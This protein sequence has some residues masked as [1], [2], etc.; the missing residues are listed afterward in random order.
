MGDTIKKALLVVFLFFLISFVTAQEQV[1]T[2]FGFNSSEF[3]FTD[4]SGIDWIPKQNGTIQLQKN[5]KTLG[6]L[7]IALTGTVGAQNYKKY[8]TDQNWIWNYD[9]NLQRAFPLQKFIGVNE[10]TEQIEVTQSVEYFFGEQLPKYEVK[11]KNNLPVSITNTKF[12]LVL[13]QKRGDD[14]T[15]G[16]ETKRIRQNTLSQ[17]DLSGRIP[18][19]LKV[20]KDYL[21]DWSDTLQDFE[22]TNIIVGETSQFGPAVKLAAIGLTKNN[23]V[24][25]S[26]ASVTIDPQIMIIGFNPPGGTGVPDNDWTDG[27]NVRAKDG[28][29]ASSTAAD[30]SL[31]LTDFGFNGIVNDSA[32]RGIQMNL[33]ADVP[34]CISGKAFLQFELSGDGGTT[35]TDTN[36]LFDMSCGTGVEDFPMTGQRDT[37]GKWW[38]AGEMDDGNFII[39]LRTERFT[40]DASQINVDFVEARVFHIAPPDNNVIA[41]FAAGDYFNL[42][43][44]ETGDV[45]EANIVAYFPFDIELQDEDINQ[46][47]DY[48]RQQFHGTFSSNDSSRS[49]FVEDGYIGGARNFVSSSEQNVILPFHSNKNVKQGLTLN[50]WIKTD[51]TR[52]TI[53]NKGIS[54][55]NVDV[56]LNTNFLGRLQIRAQNLV[57][58]TIGDLTNPC[59]SA[60]DTD[61][62]AWHMVT[63]TYDGNE[64]RIYG[65]G[66]HSLSCGF[67]GNL[68]TGAGSR[69]GCTANLTNLA[70]CS[71]GLIDD[72]LFLDTPLTETQI[73]DLFENNI[74]RFR[75]HGSLDFNG[76]VTTANKNRLDVNANMGIPSDSNVGLASGDLN[77]LT[78]PDT[79][80]FGPLFAFNDK[81]ASGLGI[82]SFADYSLRWDLTADSNLFT[83]P[84]VDMNFTR[85]EYYGCNW[86]GYGDFNVSCNLCQGVAIE[87]DLAGGNM[88]IN[89][90]NGPGDY[91]L[92][93]LPINYGFISSE[94]ACV[95]RIFVT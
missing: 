32:I 21:F 77:T 65:D 6:Y 81:N 52:G 43:V 49:V 19:K 83:S 66:Q 70:N 54:L 18:K 37:W 92:N 26:G 23:G 22:V 56:R 8:S 59:T 25:P 27:N 29:V 82:E 24:F 64:F 91:D 76:L 79:Y 38:E 15:V 87:N 85:N 13:V 73:S 17:F 28:S 12:W 48:S 1:N 55:T 84:V 78:D 39:R 3:S 30:E 63:T 60:F 10:N 46:A 75:P 93:T 41:D 4:V 11:L 71:N 31:S 53:F 16:N 69:I 88:T 95:T 42:A 68:K 61:D 67:T 9:Q 74:S 20:N 5:N 7:A 2:N 72:F 62:N 94:I 47:I 50:A 34:A 33:T 14:I 90:L 57:L 44:A 51:A 45:N 80:S 86:K 58:D 40:G 89:N 35:Y 36:F